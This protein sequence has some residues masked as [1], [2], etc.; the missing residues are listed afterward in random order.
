VPIR[1]GPPDTT[2]LGYVAVDTVAHGKQKN[3]THVRQ[4]LGC[5]R[6]GHPELVPLINELYRATWGSLHNHFR[7]TFK[8]LKRGRKTVRIYEAK[9]QTPYQRLLAS[10]A[11]AEAIKE[12]RQAV[13]ALLDLF[14]LKKSLEQKLRQFFTVLG[15]LNRESTPT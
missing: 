3:W 2:Q 10:V 6:F 1:G 11:L 7:L 12:Q 8:L 14:A 15:N 5:E 13:H 4:W 9:P